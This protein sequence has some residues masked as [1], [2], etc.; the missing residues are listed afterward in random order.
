[1][2]K[3]EK[4]TRREAK[5]ELDQKW[6]K[7]PPKEFVKLAEKAGARIHIPKEYEKLYRD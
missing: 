7:L 2:T 4:Q 1:M 5:K 6:A 3:Q